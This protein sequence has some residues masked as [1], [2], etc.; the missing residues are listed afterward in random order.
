[1]SEKDVKLFCQVTALEYMLQ[2]LYMIMYAKEGVTHALAMQ[3]HS[4]LI[5]HIN[6]TTFPISDPSR[7]MLA[8]GEI[9]DALSS[10]LRGLEEM[11]EES[12]K[13]PKG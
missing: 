8:T 13:F 7:S 5:N 1:M 6:D 2:R 3:S 9:G 4:N 11:M 12:G 10:F